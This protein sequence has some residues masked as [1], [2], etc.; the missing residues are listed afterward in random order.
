MSTLAW[1][2]LAV[3]GSDRTGTS[4]ADGTQTP[5]IVGGAG[6]TATVGGIAQEENA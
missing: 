6:T 4:V 3:G 2:A 5:A 1:S